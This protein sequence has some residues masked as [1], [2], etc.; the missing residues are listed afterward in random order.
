MIDQSNPRCKPLGSC[1]IHRNDPSAHHQFLRY[2]SVKMMLL[3]AFPLGSKLKTTR[4]S[5]S[6]LRR[7]RLL[8]LPES[9]FFFHSPTVGFTRRTLPLP[10]APSRPRMCVT[11]LLETSSSWNVI[12]ATRLTTGLTGL[13]YDPRHARFA[14]PDLALWSRQAD[15]NTTFAYFL[16]N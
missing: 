4:C 12:D 14:R 8:V 11:R 10:T 1:K 3:L 2:S 6:H 16:A 13:N 9:C 5:P 7:R 15:F